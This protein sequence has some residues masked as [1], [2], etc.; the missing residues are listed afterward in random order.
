MDNMLY[1][2]PLEGLT[3]AVWRKAHRDVFGG[4]DKYFA[5]FISPNQNMSLTEKERRDITQD[6][7]DLVPQVLVSNVEHFAWA[8]ET[9][10]ELGYTELNLNL[11]CPSGTVTA[12]RK[13][14]GLLRTP[15]ALDE[16]L[17]GA[18]E[19]SRGMTISVKT[20]IGY[21]DSDRWPE[22]LS[23]YEKYPISELIIHPRIRK[24]FYKGEP[25]RELFL[26]A[27]NESPLKLVYNGDI[28]SPEDPALSYGCDVMVGRG[29]IARPSLFREIRGGEPASMDELKRFHD[30]ILEGYMEYMP[31]ELPL[32]HRMKEFWHYFSESFDA[33][34][35]LVRKIL[36]TKKVSEYM[37]AVNSI[38]AG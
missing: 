22:I 16:F 8:C 7:T 35:K 31:G 5:P 10:L 29:L 6:E 26:E 20:R 9:L 24:D 12:K 4:A 11:G 32:L 14:S 23:I 2:A 21:E 33:D 34:P 28:A 1:V 3:L 19:V 37:N 17:D 38:F 36:K 18:F 25:D 15:D 27:M 30:M 13:G